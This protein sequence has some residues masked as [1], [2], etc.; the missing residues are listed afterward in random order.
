MLELNKIYNQDCIEKMKELPDKSIDLVF[1][2]PPYGINKVGI[3]NDESLEVYYKSLPE[4]YRIL[5]DNCFFITFASIGRL[6]D[7]FLNN[8]FRYRWQYIIYINNG[9]VRGS[10]GFNRYISVL[11]F[12]KGNAKIK[13]PLLDIFECSTSSKQCKERT[14][15]TEKRLDAIKKLIPAFSKEGD[16]I[17]DCFCGTGNILLGSKELKRN[18]IGI[19]IDKKYCEIANNKILK[20]T[21]DE[22][23]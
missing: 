13:K 17:I 10:I 11:V 20:A 8:P 4:I 18:F 1:T 5:K 6:P 12:Q 22:K 19:E 16:I 3:K 2:D 7:F 9:M 21:K 15:P 14:H 23:V